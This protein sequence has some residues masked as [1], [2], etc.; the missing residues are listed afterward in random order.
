[1]THRKNPYP[2]YTDCDDAF[3]D[4]YNEVV[5][6]DFERAKRRLL[7]SMERAVHFGALRSEIERT[8]TMEELRQLVHGLEDPNLLFTLFTFPPCLMMEDVR[9]CEDV[10]FVHYVPANR[11]ASIRKHG[12]YGRATPHLMT[13]TREIFDFYMKGNGFI[14]AYEYEGPNMVT[15]VN[16]SDRVEGVASKALSFY[17]TP[18][19]E[20]QI[21]VPVKCIKSYELKSK[22]APNAPRS[23]MDDDDCQVHPR[24]WE[25]GS[26]H[27]CDECDAKFALREDSLYLGQILLCGACR[28][29]RPSF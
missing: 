22:R 26:K 18:D 8:T 9:V 17:F 19:T 6:P 11:V 23:R 14:F 20:P 7:A 10:H 16:Y 2:Q 1:M 12:L 21:I 13:V 15:V 28:T 25:L 29:R 24:K 5:N 4:L 3:L 27:E